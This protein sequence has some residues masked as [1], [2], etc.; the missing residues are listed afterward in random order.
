M[1]NKNDELILELRDRIDLLQDEL[2]KFA[3][4]LTAIQ[5]GEPVNESFNYELFDEAKQEENRT[6]V[7]L[8]IMIEHLLKLAYCDS[9]IAYSDD[10]YRWSS[11]VDTHQHKARIS[12][13]WGF[14]ER[15]SRR[16]CKPPKGVK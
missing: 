15:L 6:L 7:F 5:N 1:D 9:S 10:K 4:A 2:A 16:L 8:S 11:S 3:R 14:T 13:R 12:I